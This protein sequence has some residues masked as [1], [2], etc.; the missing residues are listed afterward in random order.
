MTF[1][2]RQFLTHFSL[3]S[4][5]CNVSLW[6]I[7]EIARP[8]QR[9]A[10]AKMTSNTLN[11]LNKFMWLRPRKVVTDSKVW[12]LLYSFYLSPIFRFKKLHFRLKMQQNSKNL[13]EFVGQNQFSISN[14]NSTLITEE[15]ACHHTLFLLQRSTHFVVVYFC[16]ANGSHEKCSEVWESGVLLSFFNHS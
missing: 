12:P 2:K 15:F 16:Y 14:K 13:G 6:P 7:K 5:G 9:T 3:S 11:F 10:L 8:N 4:F 1:E